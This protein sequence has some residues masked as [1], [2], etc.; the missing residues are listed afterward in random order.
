[1]KHAQITCCLDCTKRAKNCHS[2]CSEYITQSKAHNEYLAYVRKMNE[3][4]RG[5]DR[6]YYMSFKSKGI[7]RK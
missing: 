1:M 6:T 5:L 7:P 4:Y 2:T 3:Y